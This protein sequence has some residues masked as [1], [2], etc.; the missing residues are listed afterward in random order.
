MTV[1]QERWYCQ[2]RNRHRIGTATSR[3]QEAGQASRHVTA[4]TAVIRLAT[5][6]RTRNLSSRH[7]RA[8]LAHAIIHNGVCKTG[9][10]RLGLANGS[11]LVT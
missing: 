10:R 8:S 11:G 4:R 3:D 1:T 6:W 9:D 5:G 7:S 2:R